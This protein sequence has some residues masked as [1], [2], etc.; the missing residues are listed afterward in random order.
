MLVLYYILLTPQEMWGLWTTLLVAYCT[1][2]LRYPK[3]K[4]EGALLAVD[5]SSGPLAGR[6]LILHSA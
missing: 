6:I 5:S 4:A 1:Q 3:S 2:A